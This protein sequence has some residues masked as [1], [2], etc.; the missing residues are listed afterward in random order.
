M[1]S[2]VTREIRRAICIVTG[3]ECDRDLA[4]CDVGRSARSRWKATIAIVSSVATS[5]V[6]VTRRS[7]RTFAVTL[8]DRSASGPSRATARR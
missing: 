8:E 3:G 5:G 2:S 7:D 1:A 6:T 4:P